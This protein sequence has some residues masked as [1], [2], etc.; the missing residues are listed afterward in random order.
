MLATSPDRPVSIELWTVQHAW[1]ASQSSEIPV[2]LVAVSPPFIH[3]TESLFKHY[4]DMSLV[5]VV[6]NGEQA[7]IQ[8]D[9]LKP[10]VILVDLEM[11][12]QMGLKIVSC[13]YRSGLNIPIIALS[14][15]IFRSYCRAILTAGANEI[16]AKLK[17]TTE[18]EPAIRRMLK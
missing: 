11:P 4:E 2:M 14:Q 16:I 12:G 7:I 9:R 8:A 10:V 5:A 1:L 3:A 18:L 17:L 15:L 13:L 6:N